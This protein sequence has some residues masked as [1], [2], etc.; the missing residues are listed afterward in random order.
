LGVRFVPTVEPEAD[1]LQAVPDAV[2]AL[3]LEV[4]GVAGHGADVR[5]DSNKA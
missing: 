5:A 4:E 3:V 1:V 2:V